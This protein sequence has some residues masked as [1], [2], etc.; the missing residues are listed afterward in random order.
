MCVMTQDYY[1]AHFL[2]SQNMTRPLL[3]PQEF[4]SVM[5]SKERL[6]KSSPS[7]QSSLVRHIISKETHPARAG[8]IETFFGP[9]RMPGTSSIGERKRVPELFQDT[10]ED[11][12]ETFDRWLDRSLNRI[13]LRLSDCFPTV[14]DLMSS[15]RSR[16]RLIETTSIILEFTDKDGVALCD[17]IPQQMYEDVFIRMIMMMVT[18]DINAD[19]PYLYETFNS[20]C[21]RLAIS[22]IH[23]LF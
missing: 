20:I 17:L 14:S 21:H 2:F 22:L 3:T 8:D 7:F 15:G 23:I 6:I 5:S 11:K 18:K 10:M 13:L 19:A 16:E 12:I 1:G 4:A 9:G